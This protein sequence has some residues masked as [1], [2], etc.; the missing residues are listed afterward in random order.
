MRKAFWALGASTRLEVKLSALVPLAS[1]RSRAGAEEWTD[2]DVLAVEYVP[3]GGLAT[4]VADCKTTKYG[5]TERVFWL[6]GVADLFGARAAYMTKDVDLPPGTRQL[7]LQLGISVMDRLDRAEFLKQA[8]EARLPQA[9]SFFDEATVRRWANI[10]S[11]EPNGT[12]A[13]QRYRR[14]LYWVFPK[15]RNLT[16]LPLYI[17]DGREHLRPT[18]RWAQAMVVDLAWLYLLAV[19]YAVDETTKLHIGQLNPALRQVVV[20]GEHEVREKEQLKVQIRKLVE[21]FEPNPSRR[22]PEPDLVPAF[23]DDLVDLS[24]R[25]SRRRQHAT[26]ALRVLEFTGVETILGRGVSWRDACPSSD[27]YAVKLASDTVRFL[28]RAAALDMKFLEV[29]DKTVEGIRR[30]GANLAAP[31]S[32]ALEVPDHSNRNAASVGESQASKPTAIRSEQNTDL[33]GLGVPVAD[34]SELFPA[35]GPSDE[36]SA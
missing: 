13:L 9:G 2:L 19:L 15:H 22:P 4:A 28:C 8:G 6:R 7:A 23:F 1:A 12:S 3:I 36:P 31:A 20:G 26:E 25:V 32:E 30:P 11:T 33:P 34:Q 18:D 14:A 17:R 21:H 5:A 10:I 29:F 24:A 27:T 16:Q 35:P